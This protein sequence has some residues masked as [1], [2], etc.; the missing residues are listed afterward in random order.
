LNNNNNKENISLNIKNSILTTSSRN[1][2]DGKKFNRNS[3]N[4]SVCTFYTYS[5]NENNVLL[6]VI[7]K[8]V[9]NKNISCNKESLPIY[10]WLKEIDL[11]IYL[12]LFM[13][14]KIYSFEKIISDLKS[15]KAI[16]TI[17]DI[18]K[19]GI[20]I[21]GHI[22]RIFVKLELRHLFGLKPS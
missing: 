7:E 1:S 5:K 15:K 2:N 13:K 17:N 9:N 4:S 11:L 14:K 3:F 21:P 6:E 20:E 8:N 19:I 22:Y 12:P 16:I 10:Q 18:K